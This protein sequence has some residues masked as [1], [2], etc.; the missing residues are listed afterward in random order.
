MFAKT[1]WRTPI[2]VAV[3][4]IVLA[5][6]LTSFSATGHADIL[7]VLAKNKIV[8]R[9]LA[10][11]S[12]TRGK[13]CDKPTPLSFVF[14]Y[15]LA[16]DMLYELDPNTSVGTVYPVGGR[17]D[18]MTHPLMARVIQDSK[19]TQY[20][21]E[22][23]ETRG[24]VIGNVLTLK[25]TYSVGRGADRVQTRISHRITATATS[26][27]IEYETFN[28]VRKI[29]T[30]TKYRTSCEVNEN[31]SKRAGGALI[32]RNLEGNYYPTLTF[33]EQ[34]GTYYL[35]VDSHCNDDSTTSKELGVAFRLDGTHPGDEFS[36]PRSKY[37]FIKSIKYTSD[38]LS[39]GDRFTLKIVGYESEQYKSDA[40]TRRPLAFDITFSTPDGQC[41]LENLVVRFGNTRF[42]AVPGS[43]CELIK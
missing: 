15:R 20:P 9:A 7:T 27:A 37:N 24:A 13:H 39:V 18:A 23:Y 14:E 1:S 42:K 21:Y 38:I 16:G 36:C 22:E 3:N 34:G 26:C 10:A 32:F 35:N 4:L 19:K 17:L 43:T 41:K 28:S 25:S 2:F 40:P 30:T 5:G 6:C 12:C 11:T 8:M 33:R 31:D 29:Q